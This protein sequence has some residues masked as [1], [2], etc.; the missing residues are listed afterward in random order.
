LKDACSNPQTPS[1]NRKKIEK[2]EMALSKFRAGRIYQMVQDGASRR[3]AAR[4]LKTSKKTVDKVMSQTHL[5]DGSAP[6]VTKRRLSAKVAERRKAVC[7]LAKLNR[8]K[9]VKGAWIACERLFPTAKALA[10]VM[11]KR[12]FADTSAGI[13]CRD[14]RASGWALRARPRVVANTPQLNAL[15][16]AFAKRYRKADHKTWRF[17]DEVWVN[18][19]DHSHAREWVDLSAKGATRPTPRVFQKRPK[20]KLMV[21]GAIGW[22]FKST[23]IFIRQNITAETYISDILTPALPEITE[24]LFMQDNARPHVANLTKKWL[25]ENGVRRLEDWPAHSPHLNPI[26]HLWAKVHKEVFKR[27]PETPE[28]LERV[29]QAVW[30]S[31]TFET[32]NK[33][34]VGFTNALQKCIERDGE[35][36]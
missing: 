18:D 16:L 14:L 7:R 19:N 2:K 23:L 22:N 17:S 24:G 32:I 20:I 15:R 21:W 25:E 30:D 13:V 6:K 31:I 12:G 26:E 8:F 5:Y 11:V 10:E 9:K 34:I 3:E 33:Y 35:P 29:V 1:K 36:W 4:R 27:R 28:E